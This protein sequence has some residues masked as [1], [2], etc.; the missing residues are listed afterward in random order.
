MTRGASSGVDAAEAGRGDAPSARSTLAVLGLVLA[1]TAGF[2]LMP[3]VLPGRNPTGVGRDA[4]DFT[5][6]L[7]ANGESLGDVGGMRDQGNG[8][9]RLRDLRGRVVLLDFWAT[10]CEP[11]RIEA[12]IVDQVAR[13]W[14]GRDVVVVGVDAD[15]PDQGNP[16]A[17][18][19]S[20]GLTYP[21]VHDDVGT[22][23]RAYGIEE[24]PTLVVVSPAGKVVAVR[25][26]VTD[27]A[28]LE[29]LIRKAL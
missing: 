26:G 22:A 21:I 11:C 28:E 13:R 9:L 25:T 5:L 20:H 1:L 6:A 14:R 19:L 18:A 17:F 12:P 15:T 23:S 16:R 2:A 27:A 8:Q 24:L 3:R 7:V 4:P 10:W 29:R